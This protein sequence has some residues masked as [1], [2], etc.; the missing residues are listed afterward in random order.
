MAVS[1]SLPFVSHSPLKLFSIISSKAPTRS[2][3]HLS[4]NT[5]SHIVFLYPGKKCTGQH[6]GWILQISLKYSRRHLCGPLQL[7]ISLTIFIFY[8]NLKYREQLIR[9]TSKT[10]HQQEYILNTRQFSH[11]WHF[12]E[13]FPC[14]AAR[15]MPPL[16]IQGKVKVARFNS[17]L[18]ETSGKGRKRLSAWNFKTSEVFGEIR[19]A[20]KNLITTLVSIPKVCLMTTNN[21]WPIPIDQRSHI[22]SHIQRIR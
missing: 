19:S 5:A 9:P 8:L 13:V 18:T 22:Q 16:L 2:F 17:K 6:I 3:F 15:R 10:H 20:K 1:S 21:L 12:C 14:I 11:L 4:R 7:Q